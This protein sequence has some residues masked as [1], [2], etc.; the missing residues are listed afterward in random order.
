MIPALLIIGAT[1]C[2][3]QVKRVIGLQILLH[4][5]SD[6][7]EPTRFRTGSRRQIA[8]NLGLDHSIR[9]VKVLNPDEPLRVLLCSFEAAESFLRDRGAQP[10]FALEQGRLGRDVVEPQAFDG[11]ERVELCLGLG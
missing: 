1:V 11:F 4:S 8:G 2:G 5:E 9:E 6:A 3:A 7:D 10:L